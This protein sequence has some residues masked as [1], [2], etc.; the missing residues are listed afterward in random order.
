LADNESVIVAESVSAVVDASMIRKLRGSIIPRTELRFFVV[1]IISLLIHGVFIYQVRTM[2]LAPVQPMKLEQIPERY[3][4]L[5]MEKPLPKEEAKKPD[6]KTAEGKG[7]AEAKAEEAPSVETGTENVVSKV[8]AQ[9]RVVA[10]KKVA[11]R[12]ARVESKIRT[13]GV[14]GMLTG[15]GSTAKGPAVVDVLGTMGAHKERSVNLDQEL[16]NMTGLV[17]AKNVDVVQKKLVKSKDVEVTHKEAIDDLIAGVTVAKTSELSKKGDIIIQK[18]ESIEGAASTNTKRDNTAINEAVSSH[19]AS[20]KMTYEKYLKRN[21]ELGGKITIRFT[22]T[23]AG[24]VSALKVLDNT[25]GDSEFEQELVRKIR[26]WQFEPINEGDV[27]VTYPFVF[28][29]S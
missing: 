8:S 22:I 17:T 3:A 13:V 12:I 14:L 6:L 9:E 28:T 2:K 19:K 20:I 29:P 25:T 23:A 7:G 26:M 15:M 11:A 16:S 4:K 10:Q 21:P 1:V 27:T 5:I 18:P 24:T